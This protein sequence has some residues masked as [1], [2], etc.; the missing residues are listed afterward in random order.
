MMH[1]GAGQLVDTD[2]ASLHI[3]DQCRTGSSIST[4]TAS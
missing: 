3:L 2:D 4:P 1:G